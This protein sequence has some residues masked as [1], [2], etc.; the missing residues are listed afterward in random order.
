MRPTVCRRLKT[1][2]GQDRLRVRDLECGQAGLDRCR[3]A[4]NGRRMNKASAR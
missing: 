4:L 3:M 2:A 1:G